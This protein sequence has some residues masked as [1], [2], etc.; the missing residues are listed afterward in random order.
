MAEVTFRHFADVEF[1]LASWVIAF[2]MDAVTLAIIAAVVIVLAIGAFVG[3][4]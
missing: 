3:K 2:A 4:L 1:K